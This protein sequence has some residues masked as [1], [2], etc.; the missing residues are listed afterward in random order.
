ME[1][2]N[3]VIIVNSDFHK[4]FETKQYKSD[5]KIIK[6]DKFENELSFLARYGWFKDINIYSEENNI[7]CFYILEINENL[8][9]EIEFIPLIDINKISKYYYEYNKNN[10]DINFG[11]TLIKKEDDI[12]EKLNKLLFEIKNK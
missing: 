9:L 1:N 8:N 7:K 4:L 10:D 2:N 11:I 6:H 3:Y 5:W 12:I